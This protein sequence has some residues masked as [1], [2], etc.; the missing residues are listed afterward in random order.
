MIRIESSAAALVAFS[1]GEE[2][3]LSI[4][5]VPSESTVL[6]PVVPCPGLVGN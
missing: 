5:T 6:L 1:V 2:P 3:V 4:A